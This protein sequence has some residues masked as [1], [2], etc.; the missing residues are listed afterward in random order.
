MDSYT[1]NYI[2]KGQTVP[3]LFGVAKKIQQTCLLNWIVKF[4]R[5]C[6]KNL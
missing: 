3:D 5:H 6:L 2:K 1:E 4:F